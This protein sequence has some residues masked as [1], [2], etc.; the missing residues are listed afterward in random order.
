LSGS[1]NGNT[2]N[3]AQATDFG[4]G[5]GGGGCLQSPATTRPGGS[6]FK[7]VVIIRVPIQS[8]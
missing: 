4:A 8:V 7:G 6:G 3:G 5:G 2:L 1:T